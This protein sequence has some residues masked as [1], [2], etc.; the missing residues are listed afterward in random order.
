MYPNSFMRRAKYLWWLDSGVFLDLYCKIILIRRTSY[1]DCSKNSGM[2]VPSLMRTGAHWCSKT[3]HHDID[4]VPA[5]QPYY[6][7][8]L[9]VK[10]SQR[11]Y[12]AKSINK[13]THSLYAA[14]IFQ[15]DK[16]GTTLHMLSACNQSHRQLHKFLYSLAFN[17]ALMFC[18]GCSIF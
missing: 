2:S 12:V 4:N 11:A 15:S 5:T 8:S 7:I 16:V 6:P 13:K 9:T 3:P 1:R 18:M 17:R 14:R 10:R